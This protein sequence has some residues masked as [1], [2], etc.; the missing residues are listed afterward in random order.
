[1]ISCN[2]L[3]WVSCMTSPTGRNPS[4]FASRPSA[5]STSSSCSWYVCPAYSLFVVFPVCQKQRKERDECNQQRKCAATLFWSTSPPVVSLVGSLA[6]LRFSRTFFS[7]ATMSTGPSLNETTVTS[8]VPESWLTWIPFVERSRTQTTIAS[9]AYSS[10]SPPNPHL[11]PR[12][13]QRIGF[14][15]VQ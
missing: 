7:F 1:M 6:L 15:A 9:P 8:W 3:P 10:Q 11:S 2:F 4:P 13:Y 5:A 14:A 12:L